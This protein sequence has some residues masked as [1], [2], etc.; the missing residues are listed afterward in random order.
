MRA[1]RLLSILLLLQT[2]KRLTARE[3]AARLEVSERTILRDMSALSS[4][5]VPVAAERGA[6]GGWYLGKAYRTNL[7][8]LSAAEAE[9]VFAA[10]RPSHVLKD[11]GMEQTSEGA[12]IKLFAALPALSRHGAERAHQRIHVDAPGWKAAAASPEETRHLPELYQA[13]CRER[14]VRFT[15]RRGDGEASERVAAPLGLVAKGRAWYLVGRMDGGDLRSYRVSRIEAATVTDDP[16]ARPP[17]FDLA[18]YWERSQ[19]EFKGALPRY[20]ATLRVAPR[21]ADELRRTPFVRVESF[22]GVGPDG[23]AEVTADFEVSGTARAFALSHGADVEVL[24]PPELRA[25]VRAEVARMAAVYG[26]VGST[27]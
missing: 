16:F 18:E 26:P 7:T 9:A 5:G 15:Y 2:T 12:F 13:V 25:E 6:G 27:G 22:S 20:V 17:D 24:A 21:L 14:R 8:G 10:R 3:L 11:L 4:A 19:R 23:W 1:D